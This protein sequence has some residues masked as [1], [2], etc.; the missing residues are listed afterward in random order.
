MSSVIAAGMLIPVFVTDLSCPD[1]RVGRGAECLPTGEPC[2]SFVY[3]PEPAHIKRWLLLKLFI[4][5]WRD[6]NGDPGP[7]SA[8][9]ELGGLTDVAIRQ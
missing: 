2:Y 1:C 9:S 4:E 8:C 7:P 5:T 6:T 3:E